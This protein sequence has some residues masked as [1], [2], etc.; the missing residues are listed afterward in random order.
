MQDLPKGLV[1]TKSTGQIVL[2]G[3]ILNCLFDTG[4]QVTSVPYSMYASYVTHHEIKPLNDLP[5]M[6]G[7]KGQLLPCSGVY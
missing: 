6:E 4:S 5:E 1:G 3:D 2:K 7:A